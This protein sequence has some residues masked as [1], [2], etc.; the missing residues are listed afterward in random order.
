MD[1]IIFELI[2]FLL[3]ILLAGFLEAAE[4][5]LSS[6]GENKIDELREQNHKIGRAH[7]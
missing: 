4:I 5:S 3:L 2:V 6:Y 7:V 1:S